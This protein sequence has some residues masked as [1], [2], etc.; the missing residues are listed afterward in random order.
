M[1]RSVLQRVPASPPRQPFLVIPQLPSSVQQLHREPLSF[2]T[3]TSLFTPRLARKYSGTSRVMAASGDAF[4]AREW[5]DGEAH[6]VL[7]KVFLGSME[8][9]K[10]KESLKSHGVTHV[11]TVN[12]KEPAFKDDFKY[13][14][15]KFG[16]ENGPLTPHL[17][18]SMSFVDEGVEKGGVLIHCTHGTGRSAAMAIAAAM[19]AGGKD[20]PSGVG[21]FHEAFR[22]VKSRRPGTDPPLPF[23]EELGEWEKSQSS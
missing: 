3:C 11:L 23:Q 1:L 19:K 5:K 14:V 21:P 9:A 2:V 10:D 20:T 15:I 4:S 8:A 6:E 7:P 16:G 22:L 12:G 17:G 13:K 18:E